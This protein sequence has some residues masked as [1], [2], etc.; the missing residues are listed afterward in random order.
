M[1]VNVGQGVVV[2]EAAL[3]AAGRAGTGLA[4]ALEARGPIERAVADD[5]S[6]AAEVVKRMEAGRRGCVKCGRTTGSIL[7][8]R[9]AAGGHVAYCTSCRPGTPGRVDQETRYRRA[10]LELATKELDLSSL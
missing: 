3:A 10:R 7:V 2:S 6:R 9:A 4:G 5:D 1:A 8:V